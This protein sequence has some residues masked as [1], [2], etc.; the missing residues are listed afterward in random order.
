MK[1]TYFFLCA[2]FLFLGLTGCSDEDPA[3]S[4]EEKVVG[5]WRGDIQQTGFGI[6]DIQLNIRA[7]QSNVLTGSWTTTDKDNTFSCSGSLEYKSTS[8]QSIMLDLTLSS[9]PCFENTVATIRF[10]DDDTINYSNT[11]V[12][13]TGTISGTMTRQ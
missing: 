10:I 6:L 13:N 3:L 8:G 5:N 11:D 2:F 7:S 12:D 9:G 4:L 1:N